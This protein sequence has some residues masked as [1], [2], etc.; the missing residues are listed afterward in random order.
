MRLGGQVR[1]QQI[2]KLG[3]VAGSTEDDIG[4]VLQGVPPPVV[5]TV[6]RA[7]FS[8]GQCSADW[9][10]A[11]LLALTNAARPPLQKQ[12]GKLDVARGSEHDNRLSPTEPGRSVDAALPDGSAAPSDLAVGPDHADHAR[13]DLFGTPTRAGENGTLQHR[14]TSRGLEN[15][16]PPTMPIDSRP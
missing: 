9:P 4:R 14:S 16:T 2:A 8:S 6:G 3:A 10:S 15:P 13:R 5:T 7:G 11:T 1:E 12:P